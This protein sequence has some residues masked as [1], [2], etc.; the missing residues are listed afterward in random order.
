MKG[1]YGTTIQLIKTTISFNKYI[2]GAF[3]AFMIVTAKIGKGG[4]RE[5]KTRSK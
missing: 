5:G 4:E 3:Y 1:F 2:F